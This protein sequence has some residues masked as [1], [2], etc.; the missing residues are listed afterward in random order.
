MKSDGTWRNAY[1]KTGGN[2]PPDHCGY[3]VS[4]VRAMWLTMRCT[5]TARTRMWLALSGQGFSDEG[6]DGLDPEDGSRHKT[7]QFSGSDFR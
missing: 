4:P 3:G 5:R 1:Q 2:F 7:G 6:V